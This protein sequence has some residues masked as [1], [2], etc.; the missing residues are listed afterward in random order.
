LGAFAGDVDFVEIHV[1][2]ARE[3]KLINVVVQEL[4]EKEGTMKRKR[5]KDVGAGQE[6]KGM[7]NHDLTLANYKHNVQAKKDVLPSG[8]Y[9]SISYYFM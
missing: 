7:S 6:Y 9:T 3:N 4:L 8:L 1:Q 5:A 2:A